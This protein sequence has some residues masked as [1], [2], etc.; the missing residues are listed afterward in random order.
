MS[1][2]SE[3]GVLRE[4]DLYQLKICLVYIGSLGQPRLHTKTLYQNQ[5][6]NKKKVSHC[7]KNVKLHIHSNPVY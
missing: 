2:I 7:I 3:P 5:K 1:L 4:A 6:E